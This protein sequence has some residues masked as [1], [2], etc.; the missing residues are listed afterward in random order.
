MDKNQKNMLKK[1]MGIDAANCLSCSYF[2]YYENFQ[3]CRLSKMLDN[4]NHFPY[5]KEQPCWHPSFSES[6]FGYRV[7]YDT[8]IVE[9]IYP[10]VFLEL[11]AEK[12]TKLFTGILI[13]FISSAAFGASVLY[14]AV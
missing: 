2:Y 7:D 4:L 6:R 13:G 11:Q 3:V 12:K 5:E 10:A 1:V 9:T 14:L 8:A